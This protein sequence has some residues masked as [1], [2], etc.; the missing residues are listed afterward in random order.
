MTVV[1][2]NFGDRR[3]VLGVGEL[4]MHFECFMNAF[5]SLM[6]ALNVNALNASFYMLVYLV[7]PPYVRRNYAWPYGSVTQ[8]YYIITRERTLFMMCSY[9][10][11]FMTSFWPTNDFDIE[12]NE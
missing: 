12:V 9:V 11:S 8:Y 3:R 5:A 4:S 1:H 7:T 2:L 6:N 10:Y